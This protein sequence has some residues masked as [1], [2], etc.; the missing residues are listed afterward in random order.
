MIEELQKKDKQKDEIMA[1]LIAR[2]EKLEK[3][4]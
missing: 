4:E 3:G 2:I 1:N